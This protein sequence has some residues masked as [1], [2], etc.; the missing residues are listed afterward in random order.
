[1]WQ[2]T[3]PLLN[4]RLVKIK[5]DNKSTVL[6]NIADVYPV[7]YSNGPGRRS[8]IWVQGCTLKCP[9]CFN[10][11]FQPHISQY[12]VDPQNFAL[13]ITDLCQEHNCE[14]ITLTGGEPFQ[15]SQAVVQFVEIIR[16]NDFNI[17]CFSGYTYPK[18]VESTH[19]DI[20]TLLGMIDLLIAGPFDISNQCY[21]TWFHDPDKELVYIT[22]RISSERINNLQDLEF[23]V[24]GSDISVTGFPEQKDYKILKDLFEKNQ[25]E[26]NLR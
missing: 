8:V 9:G 14:G 7:S 2:Q 24:E 21:R 22:D 18:L 6:L 13:K 15:Q 3:N 20:R 10:Q 17:V 16:E 5:M 25:L 26:I 19:E 23:I 4:L 1:M 11:A 12:L